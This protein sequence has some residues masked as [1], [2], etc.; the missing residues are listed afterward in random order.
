MLLVVV[1]MLLERRLVV[2][3]LKLLEHKAELTTEKRHCI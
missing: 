2:E 1:G 3:D